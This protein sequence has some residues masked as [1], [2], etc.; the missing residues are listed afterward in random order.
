MVRRSNG[1][2]R[3]GRERLRE[4]AKRNK[5]WLHSTGPRTAAGKARSAENGRWRQ[6]GALSRRQIEVHLSDSRVVASQLT[7]LRRTLDGG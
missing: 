3:E 6:K 1:L 2:T 7:E 5:P 4:A